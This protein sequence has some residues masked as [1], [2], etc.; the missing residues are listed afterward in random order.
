GGGGWGGRGG[1]VG[2]ARLAAGG[3]PLRRP[4]PSGIPSPGWRVSGIDVRSAAE[5]TPWLS[6]DR[7]TSPVAGPASSAGAPG[8]TAVTAAPGPRPPASAVGVPRRAGGPV[9]VVGGGRAARVRRGGVG[10][11]VLGVAGP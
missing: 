4:Q 7:I 5:S 1:R 6:T 11:A 3:G 2:A 10:P 8:T 9:G